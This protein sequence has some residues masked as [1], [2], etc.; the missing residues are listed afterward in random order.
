MEACGEGV[1]A[2]G[3]QGYFVLRVGDAVVNLQYSDAND[4]ALAGTDDTAMYDAGTSLLV[5]KLA[6]AHASITLLTQLDKTRK[7]S[8][9]HYQALLR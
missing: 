6:L 3:P 7:A 4:V 1:T 5:R 8:F 2:F 9:P